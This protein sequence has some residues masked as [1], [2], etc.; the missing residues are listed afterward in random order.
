MNNHRLK[1]AGLAGLVVLTIFVMA[2]AIQAGTANISVPEL[3]KIFFTSSL[4]AVLE[5]SKVIVMDIRLPRIIVGFMA[6]GIL[7]V[8]GT[9]FQAL[10]RNPLAD[11]YI[12]GVSG[13]AAL[14]AVISITLKWS[15]INGG[16][17]FFAFSGASA[18]IFFVYFIS[19]VDGR[20]PKYKM[21]LA[22]VI[23]NAFLGALIMLL[24]SISGPE[25]ASASLFWLMG[26][27]GG[28]GWREITS[29][30]P[31]II[32][33]VVVL[34]GM[35]REMNLLVLGEESA[36]HL[37][38][39]AERAKIILFV[40]ASLI[41]GAIVSI[42]GLIGFVGLVI[43]HGARLI[44]GADHRYLIPASMIMGGGFLI[45]ADTIARTVI[46]PAELPVGVITAITGGPVFVYL[47]KRRLQE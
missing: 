47:M 3:F 29:I 15:L 26:G 39:N 7:A 19:Q 37:G 6:G 33:G 23:V 13:G 34:Y 45:L 11:P 43:P 30:L 25:L 46:A 1:L 31:Y 14:G 42:C 35:S 21:L 16:L 38:I 10:L 4:P 40:A 9:A 28:A 44:W 22:G 32:P 27:L 5:S 41:T 2:Y 12:L 18:T 24:L 20:V 17:Q 8:S 36:A